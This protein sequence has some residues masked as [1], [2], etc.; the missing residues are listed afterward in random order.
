LHGPAVLDS[1]LR[2]RGREIR[3]YWARQLEA[4]ACGALDT[5]DFQWQLAI[6]LRGGVVVGPAKNLV[7]NV[8]IGMNAT[9]TQHGS[10]LMFAPT[11]E[12]DLPTDWLPTE[13][14]HACDRWFDETYILP[15]MRLNGGR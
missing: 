3:A 6:W 1:L 13:T 10:P 15:E 11:T 14:P 4:V 5:W 7:S 2:N 8:G 9:H 12:I